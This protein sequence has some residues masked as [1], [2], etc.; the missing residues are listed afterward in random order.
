M[1]HPIII[2]INIYSVIDEL[3][4]DNW[5]LLAEE[6]KNLKTPMLM[7]CPNGHKQELSLEKWRR[8]KRCDLC[9][10]DSSFR[11]KQN[12]V[13]PKRIGVYRTLALD[14]ATKISGFSVYDDEKLVGYGVFKVKQTA[15]PTARINELKNLV[16]AAIEEWEP[17]FIGMENIQLQKKRAY[18]GYGEEVFGVE[19][20]KI[21]ANLQGVLC[22]V[23][24]EKGIPYQLVFSTSWRTYC[25]LWEGE[26][27]RER[28][29]LQA[30]RK[31]KMWYGIDCTDDE[32]DAICL[33][34]YCVRPT[35]A[36][37]PIARWGEE[38]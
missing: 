35:K 4:K 13:P 29:K 6:Y 8:T 25:G 10:K 37:V 33:G 38:I 7:K 26:R 27:D 16:I 20:F 3:S 12:N 34:K 31:V 2:M 22:D 30:Q 32:A 21:L 15:D 24:F 9:L 28:Q 36:K 14:A 17:D 1:R 19:T 23:F 11:I 5:T 18:G